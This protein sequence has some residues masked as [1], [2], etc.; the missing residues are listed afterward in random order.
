MPELNQAG[1]AMQIEG[2]FNIQIQDNADNQSRELHLSFTAEFRQQDL[3]E[4]LASFRQHLNDL[5]GSIQNTSDPAEQQG[6]LMILQISEQLAPHLEAD[7]IPLDETIVIE[8]GPASPLD[9]LLNSA[10]LK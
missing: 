8:M 3:D 7:E 6:M 9:Q 1:T 2:P 5:Q 4:R 10:T